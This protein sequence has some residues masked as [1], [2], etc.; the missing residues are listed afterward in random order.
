M[1]PFR[2]AR[3]SLLLRYSHLSR[4]QSAYLAFYPHASDRETAQ[5]LTENGLTIVQGFGKSCFDKN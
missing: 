4:V 1:Q 5:M 2:Y 3:E